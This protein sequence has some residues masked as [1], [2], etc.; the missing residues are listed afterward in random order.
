VWR[1]VVYTSTTSAFG[2]ALVPAP[3]T[4]AAWIT[5]SVRPVPKN[6]Y[7]VTK[8]AN[9]LLFRRVDIEDVVT[10]HLLAL[11][12]ASS[13]GFGRCVISATTP[14]SVWARGTA[15][16]LRS[17]ASIAVRT[18]AAIWRASLGQRDIILRRLRTDR[19][20]SPGSLEK[21]DAL[22]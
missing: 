5:E 4:P 22:G 1:A 18:L 16:A 9:E 2:E 3:G 14:P 17:S 19:I 13:I 8:V 15:L 7:G 11:E 20:L 12:K 21:R 10:A 6:I